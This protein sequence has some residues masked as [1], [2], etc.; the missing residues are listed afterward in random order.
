VGALHRR[1]VRAVDPHWLL[2]GEAAGPQSARGCW[3]THDVSIPDQQLQRAPGTDRKN[4]GARL[5]QSEHGSE[6]NPMSLSALGTNDVPRR[7]TD[8]EYATSLAQSLVKGVRECGVKRP[9][10]LQIVAAYC[11]IGERT[12]RRIYC[13]DTPHVAAIDILRL[14]SGRAALARRIAAWHARRVEYWRAIEIEEEAA[15]QGRQL[16]FEEA[17][18]WRKTATKPAAPEYELARAA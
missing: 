7:A 6:I 4:P 3:R 13:S 11:R 2:R 17:R 9:Y 18:R 1:V 14:R 8:L 15:A 16:A 10:A 5:F 12:L